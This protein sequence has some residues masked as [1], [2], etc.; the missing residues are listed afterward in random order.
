M[1]GLIRHT[2]HLAQNSDSASI[3]TAN[4]ATQ[5]PPG[6]DYKTYA[7]LPIGDVGHLHNMNVNNIQ[8]YN[9]TIWM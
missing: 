7:I 9:N 4:N 3:E 5:S 6:F 2:P 8:N 1:G